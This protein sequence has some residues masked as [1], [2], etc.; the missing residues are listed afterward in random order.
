[1]RRFEF[2][3]AVVVA[4]TLDDLVLRA[5]RARELFEHGYY[6]GIEEP[7]VQ[8]LPKDR[9]SLRFLPNPVS[10]SPVVIV[11]DIPTTARLTIYDA[12]GRKVHRFEELNPWTQGIIW[13]LKDDQGTEV[14]AGVY[15]CRLEAA[16]ATLT[17]PLVVLR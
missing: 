10:N 9:W 7:E 5:Q 6:L 2:T 13:D 17:R 16:G 12:A 11:L 1:M 8:S 15:F 4:N 14:G 3:V